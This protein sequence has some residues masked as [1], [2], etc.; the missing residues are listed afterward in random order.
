MVTRPAA[1]TGTVRII[2]ERQSSRRTGQTPG[3]QRRSWPLHEHPTSCPLRAGGG[4]EG[5][6]RRCSHRAPAPLESRKRCR[7]I[8]FWSGSLPRRPT[9]LCAPPTRRACYGGAARR[10]ASRCQSRRPGASSGSATARPHDPP[11]AP[12][13]PSRIYVSRDGWSPAQR[14]HLASELARDWSASEP[15][16]PVGDDD[17]NT[18][19]RPYREDLGP[20]IARSLSEAW[21]LASVTTPAARCSHLPPR[22]P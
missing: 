15:V 10:S 18:D 3:S 2:R 5:T 20:L 6:L 16:S 12:P 7:S 14:R 13:P 4:R 22:S 9:N 11:D 8:R 19:L 21:S 17:V 1:G